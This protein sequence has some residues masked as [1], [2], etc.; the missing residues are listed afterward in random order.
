MKLLM[1]TIIWFPVS[2]AIIFYCG[3][4]LRNF[5]PSDSNVLGSFNSISKGLNSTP[6]PML[7]PGIQNTHPSVD[8][9][10]TVLTK[11]FTDYRSPLTTQVQ[12]LVKQADIWGLDYALIPA[13]AMQES[14]GC[15]TI[16]INSFNCWG[17]GI[18]GTKVTRFE[19]FEKAISQVAKTIKETYIKRGLTNPTLLEDR[20][21]P[22]SRGL[23]SYSVNFFIGKI[24]EIEKNISPT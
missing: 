22:S 7:T 2:F 11:F 3:Y 24:R 8:I 9:R 15:K 23:W 1:L 19:N 13:I 10:I 17:L 14:G 5:N 16:P 21:A 6:S 20:W 18:Y 12:T 4:K